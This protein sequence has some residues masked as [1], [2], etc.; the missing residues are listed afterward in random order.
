M[1]SCT[2]PS[3][4][5]FLDL[6]NS[7]PKSLN[8]RMHSSKSFTKLKKHFW[9]VSFSSKINFR[10]WNSHIKFSDFLVHQLALASANRPGQNLWLHVLFLPRFLRNRHLFEQKF[11]SLQRSNLC[12]QKRYYYKDTIQ[13]LL[14]F[15]SN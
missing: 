6:I 7:L 11:P 5:Y 1:A 13:K 4:L 15:Q 3:G 10:T 9:W 12:G 14:T 2:K 8:S